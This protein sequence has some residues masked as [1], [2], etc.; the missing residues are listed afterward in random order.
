MIIG[1]KGTATFAR[2]YRANFCAIRWAM[3]KLKK[4]K[5]QLPFILLDDKNLA[6]PLYQQIYEAI[7]QAIL[8]GEFSSG[9]RLPASRSLAAQ[10][11]VSR[12]TVVNAYDLLFAEGYL[13]GKIGAGT[14]VACELPD[15]SLRTSRKQPAA[16][17]SLVP[18]TALR[19][20]AYGQRLAA[21]EITACGTSTSSAIRPFENGL[22]AV[23]EFPFAVWAR[24][25]G[26][27]HRHPPRD[28]WGHGNAQGYLPLREAIAA[29][30]QSA[31]GVHCEAQQ[32]I[33]T[34]GAQQAL[35]LTTRLFLSEN[36]VALVEDPCY[37]EVRALFTAAGAQVI[38]LPVDAEGIDLSLLP[39]R[40]AQPK[41][42][43]V[44]PS[45][46]Y[47]LGVTMSLAR[48]LALLEWAK[49]ANA[50]I[51]EDDY[52]SEFR[53]AG[54][55]LTSLQGLDRHG[56]V[57]YIGTFSKTIFPTLRIGCL[58]VPPELVDIFVTARSLNDVGSGLLDQAILTEF[59]NEGHF[60]RHI[61]RMRTLY[62][63]RQSILVREC[64]KQL[65]ECLEVNAASAGMHLVG[66][67]SPG[68]SDKLVSARANSL[69]L[70]LNPLSNY[71]LTQ[72][73]RGG[74]ILGYTAFDE[75]QIIQGVKK[76][77]TVFHSVQSK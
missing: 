28:I 19:L 57:I 3:K 73:Q 65:G 74:L 45:H 18:Q 59:M 14:F 68:V 71:C 30:L 58:V 61:R 31:R 6:V 9:R 38:A 26:R 35:D 43:Y 47:P 17:K 27:I 5:D 41:L 15:D 4:P 37:Q 23:D 20:S 63:Y 62:A 52:N 8:A 2:F 67:L 21:K 46:Q 49:S 13:T 32:V 34:G 16:R 48:R 75:K 29:H 22:T 64:K 24:I 40:S 50:W 60:A 12:I 76:L 44:T 70:K 55:P 51:I 36:D 72:A 77:R 25:A 1:A 42:V 11:G 10:L 69:G 56:R 39:R 33:I 66:W 54:R 53:Y 7:R